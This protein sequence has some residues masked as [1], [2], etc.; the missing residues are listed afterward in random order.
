MCWIR[1]WPYPVGDTQRFNHTPVI[2][3][4]KCQLVGKP[5]LGSLLTMAINHF[6]GGNYHGGTISK[7]QPWWQIYIVITDNCC[8]ATFTFTVAPRTIRQR[9]GSG[10]HRRKKPSAEEMR[11][12]GYSLV[13]GSILGIVVEYV[14]PSGKQTTRRRMA[15]ERG[16]AGSSVVSIEKLYYKTIY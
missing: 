1:P 15:R 14:L 10:E 3:N 16:G 13:D 2:L 4:W 11:R 7:W 8:F 12:V 9:G 5:Y 6:Q